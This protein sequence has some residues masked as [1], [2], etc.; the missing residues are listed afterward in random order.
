M[1]VA[2]CSASAADRRCRRHRSDDR[3]HQGLQPIHEISDLPAPGD[4]AARGFVASI[5]RNRSASCCRRWSLPSRATDRRARLLRLRPRRNVSP[6]KAGAALASSLGRAPRARYERWQAAE[7]GVWLPLISRR[8]R[9]ALPGSALA[10][11]G[12]VGD[13]SPLAATMPR[14][15]ATPLNAAGC[16]RCRDR[17]GARECA[18]RLDGITGAARPRSISP[19]RALHR[20]RT[21]GSAAVP[22][23]NLRRSCCSGLHR[24]FRDGTR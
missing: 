6:M 4:P 3:R 23:I 10:E 7:G 18:L 24:R 14:R 16:T 20:R 21:P 17:P 19:R 15:A 5:I 22:E 13:A 11:A 8:C 2:C 9:R 1:I 12:W